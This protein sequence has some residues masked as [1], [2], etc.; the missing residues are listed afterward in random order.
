MEEKK[1]KTS[2]FKI[3]RSKIW[4]VKETGTSLMRDKSDGILKFK[5]DESMK[6]E[7]L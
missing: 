7:F 4:S 6:L 3:L 5:I 2:K 1:M